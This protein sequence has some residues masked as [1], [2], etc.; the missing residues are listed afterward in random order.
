MKCGFKFHSVIGAFLMYTNSRK[1]LIN[2]GSSVP[3]PAR[4]TCVLTNCG[5][6]GGSSFRIPANPKR[7]KLWMKALQL[8]NE[9]LTLKDPRVC[10]RHFKPSDFKI[11]VTTPR[12]KVLFSTA[13]PSI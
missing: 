9:I 4:V 10:E 12:K 1:I 8:D 7:K 2:S 11:N 13:V 6:T 5:P 3:P